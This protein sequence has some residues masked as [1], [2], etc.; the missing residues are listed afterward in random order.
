MPRTNH[1]DTVSRWRLLAV[2]M[3]EHLDEFPELADHHARLTEMLQRVDA[4]VQERSRLQAEKQAATRELQSSLE[5]GRKLANFLRLFL[6]THFGNRNEK[7][8]KFGVRPYRRRT[9]RTEEPAP[10]D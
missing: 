10:Q 2:T 1:A 3:A 7:L 5:D 6:K 9:R 8:V 4:L